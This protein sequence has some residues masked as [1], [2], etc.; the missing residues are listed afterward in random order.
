[1][2][3]AMKTIKEIKQIL[4]EYKEELAR[5]YRI[6]EIGIFGSYVRGKQNKKSDIDILV[7]FDEVDIPDLLRFIE[8]ERYLKRLINK[9]VDLVRKGGI[10]PE[11]KEIILREVIYL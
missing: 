8:M 3:K 7:D 2:Q 4:S 10:R 1:M 5:N 9:K 6:K 11:L